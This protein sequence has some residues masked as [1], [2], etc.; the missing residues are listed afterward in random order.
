VLCVIG[1]IIL[2]IGGCV[3]TCALVVRKKAM[4]YSRVAQKNPAYAALSLAAAVNP[5]VQVVSEDE[6]TGRITLRN[7]KTGE[8]V[9]INTNDFTPENI[10]KALDQVSKGVKPVV[11]AEELNE[12]PAGT[13]VA[14]VAGKSAT[15]QSK[16]EEAEA[17]PAPAKELKVSPA[18][19]AAQAATL[20]KFPD[21]IPVYSGGKT[22]E[23]TF[24]SIGGATVGNYTF[25]TSDEPD[26]VADFYE[27]KF[28]DAGLSILTKNSGSNDNGATVM[29]MANRADPQATVTFNAE[30][31]GGKTHVT[32]GFTRVGGQ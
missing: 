5:D 21:F 11:Q 9:T 12:K 27:K 23:S 30:V 2:I 6:S 13:A 4:D 22:L 17:V 24:N 31:D 28:T 16:A 14:P 15:G 10:G 29:M 19:A 1:A 25:T 18:H 7:K 3:T 26:V 20:K 8:K 32:V